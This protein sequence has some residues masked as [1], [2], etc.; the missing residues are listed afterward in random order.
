M[1]GQLLWGVYKEKRLSESSYIAEIKAMGVK[2]I[3]FLQLLRKQLELSDINAPIPILNNNQGSIN[4]IE[5]GC[6]A[7]EKLQQENISQSKIAEAR[8]HNEINIL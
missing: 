7:I 5:S 8:L 1:G 2:E 4:W 6:K 3:Q